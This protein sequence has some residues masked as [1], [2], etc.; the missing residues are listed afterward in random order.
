M[1]CEA[2]R[3]NLSGVRFSHCMQ[4]SIF[5]IPTPP[6]SSLSITCSFPSPLPL[7]S[8]LPLLAL[9][10]FASHISAGL[11]F[12]FNCPTL[13]III[14]YSSLC[15][16]ISEFRMIQRLRKARNVIFC[17]LQ[18]SSPL[19]LLYSLALSSATLFWDIIGEPLF[20]QMPRLSR[21]AKPHA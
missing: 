18:V 14:W 17:N 16:F 19:C 9:Y 4:L 13:E 2:A 10:F 8:S 7:T 20:F 5:D 1:G 6:I 15:H 12:L 21:H 3:R 11:K